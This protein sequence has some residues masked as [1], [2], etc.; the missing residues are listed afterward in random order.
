V[1]LMLWVLTLGTAAGVS[2]L[3]FT[4]IDGSTSPP[5]SSHAVL[6]APSR[7]RSPAPVERI[8]HGRY[9]AQIGDCVACHTNEATK[10][11]AGGF[12]IE[13]GFGPVFSPN[14][15][16][17]RDTGIGSWSKDDFYRALHAG[18]DD[19]RKHLY[20]AFPYP[21]FTKITRDDVDALKDYF[22]TVVP[23]R[24]P[25]KPPKLAWWMS[26]RAT[27]A[28]WNLLY[29]DEGTF[30]AD[31][32]KSSAWN[33]GAYLV[34]S[35]GHC[36][37]CHTPKSY[38]GGAQSSEALAGGYTMGGHDNGWY[39][40]SLRGERRA[41]LGDWSAADIVEY[42]KTGANARTAAA[43]PM[44]E[45]VTKSTSQFSDW[46]LAA[47]AVYLKSLPALHDE[48]ALQTLAPQA[49]ARGEQLFVDNCAACHMHDGGGIAHAFPALM[50][51]SAIQ[52]LAPASMVRIVL[53]GAAVP[54]APHQRSYLAMPAFGNKLDDEEVADVV[55]YV[56]NAWGNRASKVDADLVAKSRK[57]LRASVAER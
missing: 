54:A 23:V 5:L 32:Q 33:R 13:T 26:W 46:D 35:L 16:S 9:L 45:V 21:W 24:E 53:G 28:G 52:A 2:A 3:A 12:A 39:A 56:R 37:A 18:H 48:A 50:G 43:G 20:P 31:P 19:E 44:A 34:E 4:A 38:F 29:F 25:N 22:D 57:A 42:L 55:T 51:S 49:L 8:E 14:I 30:Q 17:D 40:P 27:I 10:P 11:F 1:K 41:G 15:T 7:A 47:V 36:G 6:P